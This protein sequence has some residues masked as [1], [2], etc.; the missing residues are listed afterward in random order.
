MKVHSMA[1]SRSYEN[2]LDVQLASLK[3]FANAEEKVISPMLPQSFV[4]AEKYIKSFPQHAFTV[5]NSEQESEK[6]LLSPTCC[7][8]V[9]HMLKNTYLDGDT[10]ITHKN[11]CSRC[12]SYY[13][14]GERQITFLMREYIFF[15]EN[16]ETVQSWI[17]NVKAEVSSMISS[18]GLYSDVEKATDPFFNAN[19]FR[20]KFQ[21]N[22]NLKSEFIIN[23]V[24]CGSV[25]LHLKAF[26]KSCDIKSKD[27][28]DLYSACFG[29]G[30]DRVYQQHLNRISA[31]A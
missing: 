8:P 22:Q 20:Q 10:L 6:Y 2:N 29:L 17:E 27:G 19:D 25:N 14:E 16:L 5:A 26:S 21:E 11:F 1:I 4:L 13:A 31:V 7:Y 23:K 3:C 12:E 9:F 28:N 24:A 15:S 18:L 30:Y